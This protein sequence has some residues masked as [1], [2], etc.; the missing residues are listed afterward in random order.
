M[1]IDLVMPSKH[2]ILCCSLLL[3]PLIFPSIRVFSNGLVLC[4]RWPKYWSFTTRVQGG[5]GKNTE[6]HDWYGISCFS[7][8]QKIDN[9]CLSYHRYSNSSEKESKRVTSTIISL[10]LLL[11][12]SLVI[13]WQADSTHP[14][15]F[16]DSCDHSSHEILLLVLNRGFPSGSA[17]KE[18]VCDALNN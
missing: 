1:C 9:V 4:I 6:W 10:Y 13:L 5:H 2:L 15:S 17:G 14:F 16:I 8:E 7:N 3:L 12:S 11:N 18:S